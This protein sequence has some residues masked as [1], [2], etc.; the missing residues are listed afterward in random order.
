MSESQ[1]E[2]NVHKRGER[3]ID[4]EQD[5]PWQ[6]PQVLKE[7]YTNRELSQEKIADKLN[8]GQRTV[9]RWLERH[10]IE[11][12]T[13]GGRPKDEKYK[14][15]EWLRE[16]YINQRKSCIQI[17]KELEVNKE[18]VRLQLENHGI[19]RRNKGQKPKLYA[20]LEVSHQGYE[21]W[22]NV[23]SSSKSD[24]IRYPVHRLLAVAEY[25]FEAVGNKDVHHK[26]EIRWDNRPSNIEV[27]SRSVHTTIH[28]SESDYTHFDRELI[29]ALHDGSGSQ[30]QL[31]AKAIGANPSYLY[32]L[33]R[34]IR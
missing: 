25:G 5:S 28:S 24:N 17:A 30:M 1:K 18:S 31:L 21:V 34:G 19:E 4:L 14:N 23:L 13:H 11:T 6:D 32:T 7:L 22:R 16:K 29:A 3:L 27:L 9:G 15:E 12:R 33:T 10:N 8:C 20:P 26:N 2:E